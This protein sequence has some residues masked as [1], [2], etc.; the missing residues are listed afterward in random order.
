[1]DDREAGDASDDFTDGEPFG[2][3]SCTFRDCGSSAEGSG[4][5]CDRGPSPEGSC[6]FSDCGSF[7]SRCGRAFADESSRSDGG[8]PL[9]SCHTF[10]GTCR[11]RR[12]TNRFGR[13]GIRP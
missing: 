10:G 2:E 12:P 5:F 6:V 1:M 8:R 3:S 9:G 7:T 13:A 4:T 11:F